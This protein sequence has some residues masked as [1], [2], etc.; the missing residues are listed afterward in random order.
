MIDDESAL[1]SRAR[2]HRRI[3]RSFKELTP[4]RA[5]NPRTFFYEMVWKAFFTRRK[6]AYQKPEYPDLEEGKLALTWIG[7]ASFLVQFT[8]L[9]ALIDPNFA[10]WLFWQKRVKRA[11]MRIRD[12]PQ[13]DLVL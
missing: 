12:L 1:K 4:T 10:N 11:G 3:P 7:H 2:R 8:D 13:I 9:N 6:G 5:F